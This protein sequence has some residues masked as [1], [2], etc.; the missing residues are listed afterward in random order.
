MSLYYARFKHVLSESSTGLEDLI[1]F[2]DVDASKKIEPQIAKQF[3][4]V[5]NGKYGEYQR[6]YT[7]R[8]CGPVEAGKGYIINQFIKISTHKS[9]T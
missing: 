8:D 9:Q 5:F 6:S 1:G 7:L 2:F 3:E 4:K